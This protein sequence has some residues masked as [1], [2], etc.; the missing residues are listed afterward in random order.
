MHVEAELDLGAA[1][2]MMQTIVGLS[3]RFLEFALS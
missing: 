1:D 2:A 3:E